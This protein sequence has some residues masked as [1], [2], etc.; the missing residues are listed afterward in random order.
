MDW[1]ECLDEDAFEKYL[2]AMGVTP[3]QLE[4]DLDDHLTLGNEFYNKNFQTLETDETS[5]CVYAEELCTSAEEAELIRIAGISIIEW[6][7]NI[8]LDALMG[9]WERETE[10]NKIKGLIRFPGGYHEWL[11]LAAIPMLKA[12]GIPMKCILRYRTPIDQCYFFIDNT[13]CWHGE[14]GS[15]TMHNALFREIG[16][17][18][19]ECAQR[20]VHHP[21]YVLKKYLQRFAENYYGNGAYEIPEALARLI[22]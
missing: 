12:M 22:N 16:N 10:R 19:L 4:A 20:G 15:T 21:D 6:L 14:K 7:D 11:M 17:A 3:Q 9:F 2:L 8:S 1:K 13:Q 18:Y 5:I